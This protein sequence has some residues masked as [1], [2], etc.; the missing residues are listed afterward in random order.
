MVSDARTDLIVLMVV[1]GV[2]AVWS[3]F[4]PGVRQALRE[5]FGR[6]RPRPEPPKLEVHIDH[7]MVISGGR[8]PNEGSGG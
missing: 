1:A 5:T 4:D 6:S 3:R 8:F 7:D 2:I